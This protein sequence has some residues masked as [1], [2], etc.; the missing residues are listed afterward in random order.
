MGEPTSVHTAS[1][2]FQSSL[3]GDDTNLPGDVQARYSVLE[4]RYLKLC[5]L[6]AQ[7]AI[8]VKDKDDKIHRLEVTNQMLEGQ[9]KELLQGGTT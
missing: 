4:E 9:L 5:D 7:S 1:K 6:Y 8:K 2:P 3:L